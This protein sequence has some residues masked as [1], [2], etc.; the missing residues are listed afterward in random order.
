LGAPI[1]AKGSQRCR[2]RFLRNALAYT[3]KSRR[4]IVFALIN[5]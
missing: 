5:T 1:H 3:S 4:Q 2:M